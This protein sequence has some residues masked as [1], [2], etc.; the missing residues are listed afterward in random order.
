M[1][2]PIAETTS[3]KVRG[4]SRNDI[5]SFKGIPYGGPTGGPLQP[6]LSLGMASAMPWSMAQAALSPLKPC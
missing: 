4:I 3:G 6:D 2:E 1:A 5:Y